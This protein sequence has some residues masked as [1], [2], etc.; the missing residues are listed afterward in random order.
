MLNLF[1]VEV[2]EMRFRDKKMKQQTITYNNS[3]AMMMQ[4]MD[5]MMNQST[6]YCIK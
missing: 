2:M 1:S 6:Y 4:M 5:M 3:L